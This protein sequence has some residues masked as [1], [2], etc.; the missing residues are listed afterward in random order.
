MS[1]CGGGDKH[2]WGRG[3]HEGEGMSK[4]GGREVTCRG[5]GLAHIGG[6][7]EICGKGDVQHCTHKMLHVRERMG[8]C[9]RGMGAC[10]RKG[11]EHSA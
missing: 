3:A 9:R 5:G 11:W 6:G 7:M 10:G 1:T 4:C 2:M 8:T